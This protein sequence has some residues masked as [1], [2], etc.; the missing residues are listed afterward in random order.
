LQ[1][2]HKSP[3][4]ALWESNKEGAEQIES[5]KLYGTPT[6]SGVKQ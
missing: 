6:G 1:V 2:A 4:L 3:E 5:R